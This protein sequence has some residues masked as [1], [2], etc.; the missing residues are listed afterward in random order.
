MP[1]KTKADAKAK[2]KKTAQKTTRAQGSPKGAGKGSPAQLEPKT[3]EACPADPPQ[4]PASESSPVEGHPDTARLLTSLKYQ[5]Q[6]KKST[7]AHREAAEKILNEYKVANRKRKWEI[8]NQLATTGFKDLSAW[9][10][11]ASE[12]HG[13]REGEV[14]STTEGMFTKHKI[15]QLNGFQARDFTPEEADQLLEDLLLESEGLYKH[16][17]NA[18]THPSNEALNRYFYKLGNGKVS[19]EE[20]SVNKQWTSTADLSAKKLTKLVETPGEEAAVVETTTD[21]YRDWTALLPKL[22]RSKVQLQGVDEQLVIALNKLAKSTHTEAVKVKDTLQ[23][24]QDKLHN[25]LQELLVHLS[26]G[27]AARKK[28][29]ECDD[30]RQSRAQLRAECEDVRAECVAQLELSKKCW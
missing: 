4:E 26:E 1:G 8:M 11:T 27:N 18:V 17:R 20:L 2:A 15:L 13:H 30:L 10:H 25:K 21:S 7:E 29:E 28:Q 19:E 5:L 24:T 16:E 22:R 9:E 23:A 3:A 12:T 6:S 14:S